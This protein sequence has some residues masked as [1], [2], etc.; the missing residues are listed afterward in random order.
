MAVEKRN[1]QKNPMPFAKAAST[2]MA[3]NEILTI[4][5]SGFVTPAVAASANLI[6]LSMQKIASTDTDYASNTKIEVDVPTGAQNYIIDT[7]GAAVAQTMVGEFFDLSDSTTLNVGAAAT[8]KHCKVLEILGTGSGAKVVVA[9]N[10]N[11][12]LNA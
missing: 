11:I 8:V 7:T 12:V 9:F 4:N 1:N 5:S 6:G 2:A 10:P 3:V